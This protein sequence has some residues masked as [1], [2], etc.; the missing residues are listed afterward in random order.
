MHL[1]H[2]KIAANIVRG[3][4]IF[5]IGGLLINTLSKGGVYTLKYSL[6]L[7]SFWLTVIFCLTLAHGLQNQ[8]EW[9][10]W[11]GL[12]GG[13]YQLFVSLN[14]IL[15][16]IKSNFNVS[17]TMVAVAIIILSFIIFLLLPATRKQ[18]VM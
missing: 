9:S 14:Q 15:F 12:L 17:L 13:I 1:N 6:T 16:F 8:K 11:L 4:L 10:W 18:C 3:Y 7:P 2:G 5:C